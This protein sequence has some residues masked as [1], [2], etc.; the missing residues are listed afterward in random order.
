MANMADVVIAVK[1]ADFYVT[2]PSDVTADTCYE[3]GTVDILADDLDGAL[4]AAKDVVALLP[5]NNLSPAP[6]YDFTAPSVAVDTGASAMDVICAVADAD[7]V[8]ELK[9]GYATHCVTALATVGGTT[10][11]FVAFDGSA[12]CPACAY[13]AEAF[14]SCATLQSA[15]PHCGRR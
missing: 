12:V 3:Q 10:V 2:T 11:G 6:V 8:V 7:S 14:V 15:H 1:D 4:T 13:K 5:G 9:G